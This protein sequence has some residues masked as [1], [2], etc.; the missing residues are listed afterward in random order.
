[1]VDPMSTRTLNLVLCHEYFDQ[2]VAGPK[3]FELRERTDYWK[4]RIVGRPYDDICLRRGYTLTAHRV[5]YR[6]YVEAEI[7]HPHFGSRFAYVFALRL[8]DDKFGGFEG[9]PCNRVDGTGEMCA[10]EL[11]C[12][13]V[14]NCSCHMGNPPCSACTTDRIFCP[15][16]GWNPEDE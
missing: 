3:K 9:D 11:D 15:A 10:G 5:P 16:C 14:E 2:I 8:T 12:S 1:M 7:K 4:K 6:G 13:P